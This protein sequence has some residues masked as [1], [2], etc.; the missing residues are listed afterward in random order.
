MTYIVED[1]ELVGAALDR[2]GTEPSYRSWYVTMRPC[3]LA[4]LFGANTTRAHVFKKH[5]QPLAHCETGEPAD[6]RIR[7][8]I[9]CRVVL[10][11][12]RARLL[13]SR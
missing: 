9:E 1:A 4:R 11:V 8:A 2:P 3:W 12:P 13:K 7:E 6:Y 5:G 10:P